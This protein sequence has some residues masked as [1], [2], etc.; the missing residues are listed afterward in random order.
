CAGLLVN[1]EIKNAPTDRDWDPS[2]RA[3]E[4]LVDLLTAREGRDRVLVS[5]FNLATIDRVRS[6]AP[7]L[8][9]AL[10]T[11]GTDPLEA[12]LIAESHGHSALHP[13]LRSVAGARA[14]AVTAR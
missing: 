10:L 11:Y 9:T 8:R 5:S 13:D 4:L 6:L 14:G 12:L 3:A 2:D 7:G 1:V